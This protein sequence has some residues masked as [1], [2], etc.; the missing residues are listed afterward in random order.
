MIFIHVPRTGGRSIRGALVSGSIQSLDERLPKLRTAQGFV[1]HSTIQDYIEIF[2]EEEVEKEYKVSIVR[3][4][5]DRAY[6][7]WRFF[8]NQHKSDVTFEAW[9]KEGGYFSQ[10]PCVFNYHMHPL[11]H[12][13]YYRDKNGNVRINHFL[14]FEHLEEDFETIRSMVGTPSPIGKIGEYEPFNRMAY[15][16]SQWMIDYVAGLNTELIAKFGYTFF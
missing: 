10:S 13:A 11:D 5:W 9:L 15:Y 2:G 7:C 8:I 4:P 3:N 16:T 14:C 1:N 6:A 12:M